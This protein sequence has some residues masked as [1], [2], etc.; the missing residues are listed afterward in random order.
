MTP[1]A[2]W[3]LQVPEATPSLNAFANRRSVYCYQR[4]RGH[5]ERQLLDAWYIA[6]STST[7]LVGFVPPDRARL[8]VHRYASRAL[9]PDNL[10]G[11][12]KP[13]IDALRRL[14]LIADDDPASLTLEVL[15]MRAPAPATVLVLEPWPL[16]APT[17][18]PYG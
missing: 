7:R 15:P 12:L 2:L 6:R 13:V 17:G 5:W 9:D 8:T 1:A 16:E 10:V 4:L 3:I 11:G 18:D 14:T